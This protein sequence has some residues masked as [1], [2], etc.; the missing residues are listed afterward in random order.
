MSRHVSLTL[1]AVNGEALGTPEEQN[2]NQP[3][4]E[5]ADVRPEGHA[6][7]L[8]ERGQS[9]HELDQEP[10]AEHE[11]GG[12]RDRGRVEAEEDERVHVGPGVE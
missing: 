4:G 5:T 12:D 6:A 1:C 7:A 3:G 2:E 8:S 10:V 11:Y 9:A